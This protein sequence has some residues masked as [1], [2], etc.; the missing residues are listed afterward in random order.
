[1]ITLGSLLADLSLHRPTQNFLASH[2]RVLSFAVAPS[3]VLLGLLVGSYPQEHEDWA[4]WSLWM[5][6]TFVTP[7]NGGLLVP[8]GTDPHRR[9][10]A[11]G[12]QLCAVAVFLSPA[13]REAL[14]HRALLWLGHHSFAVYL[15]HGTILRTVGVWVAYGVRPG[16]RRRKDG[17]YEAYTPVR[18]REAVC[19]AVVVF[20][21]LSYGVAWAW[22]RWV[23]AACARATQWLEAKVFQGEEPDEEDGD[24]EKALRRASLSKVLLPVDGREQLLVDT[25]SLDTT[26]HHV[27]NLGH[28]HYGRER[29][30]SRGLLD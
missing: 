24:A 14:S 4:S 22:M 7:D 28:L 15:T 5:S 6:D 9:F 30:A 16:G 3:L 10:S 26:S 21:V 18:S 2:H 12:V 11:L 13:L 27:V 29:A 8:K 1:M 17:S 19:A 25:S 20:V 23:D